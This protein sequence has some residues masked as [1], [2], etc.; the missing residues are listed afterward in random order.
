MGRLPTPV[1]TDANGARN[2][3]SN[4][5]LGAKF[6]TGTTL[7]DALWLGMLPT[8]TAT[9]AT[10][11]GR[12]T[13]R[14]ARNGG[15]LVEAVSMR[16]LPTPT[17]HLAKETGAPSESSRNSPTLGMATGAGGSLHPQFVEWM[18]GFPKGWT[19]LDDDDQPTTNT[20]STPSETPSSRKSRK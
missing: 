19:D 9:D 4:R 8:P 15:N 5:K 16:L 6:S 20:D 17:A 13:E 11:G 1:A 14:K 12:V 10:H 18:M 7:T 3:T 2:A